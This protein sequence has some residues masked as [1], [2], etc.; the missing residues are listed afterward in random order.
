MSPTN[1]FMRRNLLIS[2]LLVQLVA[3]LSLIAF[4]KLEPVILEV[5]ELSGIR[6]QLIIFQNLMVMFIPVLIGVI[7]D[8]YFSKKYFSIL[9]CN[10]FNDIIVSLLQYF[11]LILYFK[12]L[13]CGSVLIMYPSM[14]HPYEILENS[15]RF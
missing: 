1:F 11:K 9:F 3:S 6:F 14:L 15:D 2:L 7:L 10:S 5:F 8:R 13:L 12:A 4:A